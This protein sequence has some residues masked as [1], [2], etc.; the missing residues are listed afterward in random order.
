MVF[1]TQAQKKSPWVIHYDTGTCNGCKLEVTASLMPTFD[2]QQF[3]VENVST[4]KQAD[5]LLVSGTVNQ[6]N[7]KDLKSIYE[8]MIEPKAVVAVGAC[9]C[10]GGIFHECGSIL[11]G[12][13]TTMPVDVFVP[14]CACRPE[15][16]RDGVLQAVNVLIQK[17]EQGD[18]D[19]N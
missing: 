7:V 12:V 3:G 16:I 8:Q 15:S 6:E 19:A 9:S 10:T 13:G 11:A 2:L 18:L 17:S 5:I 4:P 1:F 14:G